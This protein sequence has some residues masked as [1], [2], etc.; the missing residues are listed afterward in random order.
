[1][2]PI[3]ILLPENG[4]GF[5]TN[6]RG[7]HGEFQ[8][9]QKS[10]IDATLAVASAWHALHPAVPLSIGQISKKGGGPL[11][12]H[13]SHRL[14]VDV[15]VRPVRTDGKNLPVKVDEAEYDRATTTALIE[16]WWEKAP[17][18]AIFFNDPTV[19]AARL[20]Q[21][22]DGHHNHFH[23]RMRM[24]G[25]TIKI[26]DRGSDVAEVQ[27]KLGLTADGRFGSHTQ[28]A[29]EEFQVAHRLTPDG[30]VEGATWRALGA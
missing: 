4:S 20:S 12:P 14:G 6:N 18:Q 10:T 22:V 26:G 7:P 21:F 24:K 9:G 25:A 8:F 11:P 5:V 28:H 1:M 2:T 27:T 19:I 16:L 30:V 15:D 29:V 13:K 3:D 17:V 23:V